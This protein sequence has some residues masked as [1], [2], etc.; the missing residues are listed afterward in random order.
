MVMVEEGNLTFNWSSTYLA[1][2]Q[3]N[4]LDRLEFTV[5]IYNSTIPEETKGNGEQSH[6]RVCSIFC[7]WN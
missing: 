3:I 2:I 4:L 7:H 5:N 1:L 6:R